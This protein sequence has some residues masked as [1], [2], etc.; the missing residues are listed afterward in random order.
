MT[1]DNLLEYRT[2]L[3]LDSDE[4]TRVGSLLDLIV[5]DPE[6]PLNARIDFSF[7]YESSPYA[8]HEI[9]FVET[10]VTFYL[11]GEKLSGNYRQI[12]K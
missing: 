3:N 5:L 6:D 7:G 4:R 8:G 10:E 2:E 1:A 9:P 11:N 12:E